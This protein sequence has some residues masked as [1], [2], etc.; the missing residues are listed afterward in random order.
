MTKRKTRNPR[1][2]RQVR[3][4]RFSGIHIGPAPDPIPTVQQLVDAEVERRL[5]AASDA[6]KLAAVKP[7]TCRM[8]RT[9]RWPS[10]WW[11]H[12]KEDLFPVS[13]KRRWPVQYSEQQW[14]EEVTID[15]T[16]M[17]IVRH[18]IFRVKDGTNP[19]PGQLVTVNPSAPLRSDAHNPI[20]IAISSTP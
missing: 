18:G 5:K 14:F 10:T 1:K 7:S 16:P 4:A 9:V 11:Q 3:Q 2:P 6:A 8:T 20:G 19:F 12:V 13:W 15:G 17:P